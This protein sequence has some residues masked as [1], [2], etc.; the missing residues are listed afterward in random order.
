MKV[1]EIMRDNRNQR[2]II[3]RPEREDP[4]WPV[5]KDVYDGKLQSIPPE[6][7]LQTVT[8]TAWSIKNDC[9]VIR[10]QA[11]PT[12]KDKE[13]MVQEILEACREYP[14]LAEK[15]YG[16]LSASEFGQQQAM[17]HAVIDCMENAERTDE[18]TSLDNLKP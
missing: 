13:T 7:A 15:L 6:I 16:F 3:E 11:D 10:L 14:E 18:Y 9:A 12:E 5:V 2:V 4:T 17:A 1:W 8:E